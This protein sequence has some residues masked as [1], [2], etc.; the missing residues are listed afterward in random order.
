[1][2]YRLALKPTSATSIKLPTLV[3]PSSTYQ[4]CLPGGSDFVSSTR[5]D[6]GAWSDDAASRPLMGLILDGVETN[7]VIDTSTASFPFAG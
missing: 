4:Q 2:V 6:A 3:L 7:A 1:V 5:T